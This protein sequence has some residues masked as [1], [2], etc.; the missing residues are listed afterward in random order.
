MLMTWMSGDPE[1]DPKLMLHD[2]IEW[3]PAVGYEH[4]ELGQLEAERY[5]LGVE[6]QRPPQPCELARKNPINGHNVTL[7]D[8]YSYVVP[9]ISRLPNKYQIADGGQINRVVKQEYAKFYE[10]GM[11]VVAELMEQFAMVDQIRDKTPDIDDCSME[12]N[13]LDGLRLIASAISLNYRL[14]WELTFMLGLLD[15]RSAAKAF[16]VFCELSEIQEVVDAKKKLPP[17][18]IRVGSI[19]SSTKTA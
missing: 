8:G 10:V 2:G 7:G 13:A 14:N 6:K 19:S 12:V 5:W 16:A 3:S 18:S 11:K 4:P 1:R 15:E 17:V 9:T